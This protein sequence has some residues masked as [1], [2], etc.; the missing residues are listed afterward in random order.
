MKIQIILELI[1][2]EVKNYNTN[3]TFKDRPYNYHKEKND[4]KVLGSGNFS[5]VRTTSDPHL[6]K[7]SSV[8]T[9][10]GNP[11]K[12]DSY[13]DF[14]DFLLKNKL[15]ENPYFPRVYKKTSMHG[16]EDTSHH[17]V[18]M[19]KLEPISNAEHDDL[20]AIIRK[21]FNEKG[22]EEIKNRY[23]EERGYKLPD[24][25][26]KILDDAVHRGNLSFIK[27]EQLEKALKI[28]NLYAKHSKVGVDIH[29]ENI[30]VRRTPVGLQLVISDPFSFKLS[31]DSAPT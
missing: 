18:V 28:L 2:P 27:D 30:M 20:L 24:S 15:W 1:E 26:A 17:S 22:R 7:K 5:K 16:K 12:D 14:I 11:E 9:T 29:S 4:P 6:V 8:E 25:I 3:K 23:S 13:W 21:S 31:F 10:T 19:E